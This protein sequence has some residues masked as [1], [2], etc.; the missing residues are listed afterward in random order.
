LRWCSDFISKLSCQSLFP[1][2]LTL[3]E[4]FL[5]SHTV[6]SFLKLVNGLWCFRFPS[7][8]EDSNS[9]HE[10]AVW[11]S[12]DSGT[13]DFFPMTNPFYLFD[14]IHAALFDKSKVVICKQ[15]Q[16]TSS[17]GSVLGRQHQCNYVSNLNATFKICS[18]WFVTC[19]D[20]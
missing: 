14:E 3:A 6:S 13:L 4:L 10:T 9:V 20:L 2:Y 11:R 12:E 15:F 1:S 7:S 8:L 19:P 5:W 18:S 16:V 17:L